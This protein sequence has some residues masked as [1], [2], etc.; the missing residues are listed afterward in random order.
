MW[1][2]GLPKRKKKSRKNKTKENMRTKGLK[3]YSLDVKVMKPN[4]RVKSLRGDV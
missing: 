4:P 3:G 2:R 1:S